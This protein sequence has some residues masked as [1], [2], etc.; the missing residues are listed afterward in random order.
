MSEE[1]KIQYLTVIWTTGTVKATGETFRKA[2]VKGAYI[3]TAG[4][5]H[6]L[7][8]DNEARYSVRGVDKEL[9]E[10]KRDGKYRI[11]FN[12]GDCWID[13][14]P[15]RLDKHIIRVKNPIRIEWRGELNRKAAEEEE[16]PF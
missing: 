8:I 7:M 1:K 2:T 10:Y 5:N 9:S 14:R 12:E 15:D 13:E 3:N 16:K 11:Y 4:V 6:G